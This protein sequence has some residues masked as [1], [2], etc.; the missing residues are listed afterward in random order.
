MD[1][2]AFRKLVNTTKSTKEIAREA[3]ERE[4]K[5]KR[6]D[7]DSSDDDDGADQQAADTTGSNARKQ[8]GGDNKDK[9]SASKKKRDD[10]ASLLYRD[11]AKERREGKNKDY[12]GTME[13][14][15]K[16][17]DHEMSQF[18]GGDE[19]HTHLVKGLDFALAQKVRRDLGHTHTKDQ[20]DDDDDD[21]LERMM[22]T[23]QQPQMM[24]FGISSTEEAMSIVNRCS[25]AAYTSSMLGKSVI[26][27]L[28]QQHESSSNNK[29]RRSAG[30]GFHSVASLAGQAIQRSSV[31]FSTD[32]RIYDA[33]QAWQ[34]PREH[35]LSRAQYDDLQGGLADYPALTSLD[36]VFLDRIVSSLGSSS[37]K[38]ALSA[39]A[40]EL[41]SKKKRKKKKKDKAAASANMNVLV[42][43]V[44]SN[45]NC[46]SVHRIEEDEQE[47]ENGPGIKIPPPARKSTVAEASENETSDDDI[48]ADVGEYQPPSK[49][50]ESS[51]ASGKAG[52]GNEGRSTS[53]SKTGKRSIFEGLQAAVTDD[54]RDKDASEKLNGCKNS[55]DVKKITIQYGNGKVQSSRK[56]IDRDIFGARS[57]TA[58]SAPDST[59]FGLST[60]ARVDDYGEDMDVDFDGTIA[61]RDED[62]DTAGKKKT[63]DPYQTEAAKE[64]GGRGHSKRPKPDDGGGF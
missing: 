37:Q 38:A 62:E 52:Q 48:F 25:S 14:A 11:R 57:T 51:G 23:A 58:T 56:V 26:S 33:L 27:Y 17:V 16:F 46:N 13:T 15:A 55:I 21:D 31:S 54:G 12:E 45:Q 10:E 34:I 7:A 1:N 49:V 6:K 28:K 39:E 4:F 42:S 36:Q 41:A 47:E 61:M 29:K 30:I 3:V 9:R 20:G 43:E 60:S 8:K 64:Y 35:T 24:K 19:S 5:R 44:G 50:V 22:A 53:N 2:D 32:A 18:L 40:K 59:K 63:I